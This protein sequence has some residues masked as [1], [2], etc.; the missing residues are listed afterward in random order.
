MAQIGATARGG[1]NRQALTQVDKEGRDLFVAWCE[2]AGC[3]VEIDQI[4]N[5][6][7]R[8]PGRDPDAPAV[9]IASHL[10]T[11]PTGGRFDGVYGVLAG[12]EI[13]RTLNDAGLSTRRPIVV[14][15]WTNE[16]GA[17]FAPAM[18][19]SGVFAGS[20]ALDYAYSRADR[21]GVGVRD[22]LEAIGYLGAAPVGGQRFSAAF[23]VHIE[24]GPI[25]EASGEAIG[26]VTGIQGCFWLDVVL[27]GSAAHAGTTPMETRR[28]PWRAALPIL[29][30]A[31]ASA[32]AHAPWG[33]CTIGDLAVEPGSRNTVPERLR[34]SI[35]LRHPR[36]EILAVMRAELEAEVVRACAERRIEGRIE[37]VWRMP[38]TSFD[39][40]LVDMVE[41]AA[42]ALGLSARRMVSGAG[43]DSFHVASLAPTAMIFVPCAG[44]LSHNE[45]ESAEPDDLAAGADVLLQ[46]V[47]AS[48]DAP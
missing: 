17:R 42:A 5:I 9:L 20:H 34:I 23:E 25:L 24:Q 38:P 14:A 19:G 33:R 18:L 4:G 35:D 40:A 41:A 11:Q 31:F 22:A 1:C 21:D 32:E 8:R 43:H 3:A 28:D 36:A 30:A 39:P 12:L 46:A 15:S 47:L 16:E 44:G 37:E 26:V 48:A 27:A 45:A 29:K 10:D 2:A 13:V 7:A 6:F